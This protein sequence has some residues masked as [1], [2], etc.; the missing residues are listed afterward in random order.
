M[1][2]ERVLRGCHGWMC[3]TFRDR[4]APSTLPRRPEVD[5]PVP[6]LTDPCFP[7]PDG[8]SDQGV[9]MKRGA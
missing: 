4:G 3:G 2:R 5:P 9:S 6:S 7:L 8:W 1:G